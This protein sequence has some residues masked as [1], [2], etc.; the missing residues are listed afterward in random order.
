MRTAKSN[1]PRGIKDVYTLNRRYLAASYQLTAGSPTYA[2]VS[3]ASSGFSS[4]LK[5]FISLYD[6]VKVNWLKVTFVPRFRVNDTGAA[7]TDGELPQITTVV[8]YD[9]FTAPTSYDQVLGQAGS[10][11]R[12]LQEEFSVMTTPRPLATVF[13]GTAS[14]TALLPQDTWLNS[15]FLTTYN[16][17][18]PA[19]KFGI[20]A[21]NNAPANGWIDVYQTVSITLAQSVSG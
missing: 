19:L 18:M 16:G 9:D 5:Q 11:T 4:N 15:S 1:L 21:I 6:L 20:T 10:V 8:N 2:A 14:S 7:G 17:N 12:R 3:L 13:G